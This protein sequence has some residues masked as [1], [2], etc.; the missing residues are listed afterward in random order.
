[1]TK[2]FVMTYEIVYKEGFLN[3]YVSFENCEWVL[4]V[5]ESNEFVKY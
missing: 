2:Q 5:I 3:Y 4:L 1:M